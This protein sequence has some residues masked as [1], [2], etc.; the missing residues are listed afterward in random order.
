M[1]STAAFISEL[2]RAANEIDRLEKHE[3]VGLLK[4]ASAQIRDMR[5]QIGMSGAPANDNDPEDIAS[6]LNGMA[7]VPEVFIP[8]EIAAK[9]LEG[10]EAI[11]TLAIL[12]GI[13]DEV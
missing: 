13:K 3:R 5:D 4:R 8:R 11:R 12:L 7:E 2:I 9:L 1:T 10:A 6:E